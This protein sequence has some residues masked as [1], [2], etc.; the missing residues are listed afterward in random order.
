M[1]L[2]TAVGGSLPQAVG[3]AFRSVLC[4]VIGVNLVGGAIGTLA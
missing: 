3:V 2:G 4:L 1:G